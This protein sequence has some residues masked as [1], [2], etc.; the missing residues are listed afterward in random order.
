MHVA[1]LE[2]RDFRSYRYLEF[3]P[4]RLVNLLIGRNGAGKTNTLEA[5]AYLVTL[6]SLRGATDEA[7]I[8]GEAEQA[9][10]RAGLERGE[11]RGESLVEIEIPRRGPRRTQVDRQRLRRTADL[12][13]VGRVVTF[14]PDDLDIVKRGPG[15]RRD[16]LD[17]AAVQMRPSAAL[18][19]AEYDRALRQ[20]NAFLKAGAPDPVTLSVWDE[21]LSQ[22]GG[23]VMARRASI[24]AELQPQICR[25]YR[26]IA[27]TDA[28]L[29][30]EYRSEW[31]ARADPTVPAGEQA[32]ALATALAVRIR[33]DTERRMTTV[34]PHRDDP[35]L[36]LDRH[37]VRVHG[38]QGE[39]RSTALALR[40]A[41]HRAVTEHTGTPPVLLLDD[42]FSE[43]DE[44]RAGRLA[45]SLPA[46]QTFIT[47]ARPEELPV[48]GERWLVGEG[49][50]RKETR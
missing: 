46:T 17:D 19:F 7:L 32:E 13:D 4:D 20:R 24:M 2:L 30:I 9:V 47:S 34:G 48:P 35:T 49:T 40:L 36:L 28:E 12:V 27:A 38:S 10:V 29:S 33:H 15:R 23:K 16:L 43:L 3:H 14:L 5:I 18:D 11:G 37:D 31:G 44:D 1:W 39:Q 25:A 21:R 8:A 22:A 41:V 45:A 26:A 50:I 42:V 6:K